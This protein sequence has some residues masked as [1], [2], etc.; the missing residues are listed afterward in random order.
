MSELKVGF[1]EG[2]TNDERKM[3][4]RKIAEI[5]DKDF[6]FNIP[7]A[8]TGK[9]R[10]DVR[11]LLLNSKNEIC[12]IKSEKHGYM[13]IPGGGIDEGEN[14]IDALRRETEEET[15]WLIS[16]IKP[17]GYTLER[18]ED[19]R[20]TH[21]YDQDV[22]FV[23]SALPEKEVGTNYMEDE[24]VEGFRP[25]WIRLEDFIAEQ[26]SIEGKIKNYYGCFSNRRDL[27]IAKYFQNMILKH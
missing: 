1:P 22:S 18:R 17:I 24:I 14:I 2:A 25:I 23:F 5:S 12:V 27:L 6:G 19:V 3:K 15:G 8:K 16:D 7:K 20:N 4:W 26:A 11:I 21:D 9:K 10:Y 13:Q